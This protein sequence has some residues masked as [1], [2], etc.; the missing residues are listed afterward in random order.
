MHPLFLSVSQM[1]LRWRSEISDIAIEAP[2]K[3]RVTRVEHTESTTREVLENLVLLSRGPPQPGWGVSSTR[4]SENRSVG[5]QCCGETHPAA[6]PRA[7]GGR[8]KE[9]GRKPAGRGHSSTLSRIRGWQSEG[10]P[11]GHLPVC[12]SH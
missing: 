11:H 1:S 4:Q 9:A 7:P 12:A 10:Q 8:E 5:W 2:N 3:F 6:T